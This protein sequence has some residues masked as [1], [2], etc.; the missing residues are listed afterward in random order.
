MSE[1]RPMRGNTPATT[2][3]CGYC[4]YRASIARAKEK[5]SWHSEVAEFWTAVEDDMIELQQMQD[6]FEEDEFEYYSED[7][8]D[9][10]GGFIRAESGVYDTTHGILGTR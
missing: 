2:M 8:P 5:R 9:P 4:Y 7:T 3:S 10:Y 1:V 6:E